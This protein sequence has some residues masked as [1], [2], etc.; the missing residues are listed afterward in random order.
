MKKETNLGLGLL[1]GFLYGLIFHNM[2]VGLIIGGLLGLMIPVKKKN[3]PDD[4]DQVNP[5]G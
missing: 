5:V 3:N 4:N 1:L 2:V